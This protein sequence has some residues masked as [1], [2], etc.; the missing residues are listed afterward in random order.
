MEWVKSILE[1]SILVMLKDIKTKV[2][3]D[4]EKTLQGSHEGGPR[5]VGFF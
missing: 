3:S 5:P 2:A 4:W 1:V